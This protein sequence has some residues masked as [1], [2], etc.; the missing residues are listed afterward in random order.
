[1]IG[2]I[3]TTESGWMVEY[4]EFSRVIKDING[5]AYDTEY[6]IKELPVMVSQFNMCVEGKDVEFVERKNLDTNMIF[7]ELI[8][9]NNGQAL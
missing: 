6:F 2:T 1:M 8:G 9:G 4:K 5:I 7:A 3:K